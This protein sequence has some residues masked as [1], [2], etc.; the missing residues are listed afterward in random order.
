MPTYNVDKYIGEAIESV[1]KQKTNFEYK[2]YIADDCSTDDTLKI[3]SEYIE[4]YPSK[5]KVFKSE[6][7]SGLLSNTNRVYDFLE[8]EYVVNLDGDDY[9]IDENSLQS[10]VN[11]L[12]SHPNCF[13]CAGN[14]Q[15]LVNGEAEKLLRKEHELGRIYTFDD[16]LN[17]RMPFFHTSSILLRNK[18]FINGL[19][20]S[21]KEAVGTFEECALRGEN[22]RRVL[23]LE[24][25]YLYA[26]NTII[27]VYRIHNRG[28]WQGT[29]DLRHKIEGAISDNFQYKYFGNK[30][31]K[32]FLEKH[33]ESYC[34][35]IQHLLLKENFLTDYKLNTKDNWL[36]ISLLS[37][38]A[39]RDELYKDTNV[40]VITSR[41][42]KRLLKI[43][44]FFS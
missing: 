27:S 11:Y 20:L 2:I 18:I 24:Q 29:T 5:I 23:H 14:T 17:D 42:K 6:V 7:N 28:L 19:P 38:I 39:S 40:S 10:Q 36:F 41:I 34:N 4:K 15:Y 37:D 22:F 8:C 3:V 44:K 26:M 35:L 30:Y 33:K 1:L 9:W 25:G 21:F 31:G 13:L 12:D 43:F 32:Y 16:L